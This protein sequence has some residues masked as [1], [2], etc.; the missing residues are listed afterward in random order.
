MKGLETAPKNVKKH[1]DIP[2]LQKKSKCTGDVSHYAPRNWTKVQYFT[3]VKHSVHFFTK[4][5][6]HPYMDVKRRVKEIM[7]S[8][9][10]KDCTYIFLQKIKANV[11]NALHQNLVYQIGL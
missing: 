6:V 7:F 9:V 11:Q 4:N 8:N 3:H 10:F 1:K 2:F 5:V